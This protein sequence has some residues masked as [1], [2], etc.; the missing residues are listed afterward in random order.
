MTVY[1]NHC[2]RGSFWLL[3]NEADRNTN[4]EIT[5]RYGESNRVLEIDRGCRTSRLRVILVF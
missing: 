2:K 5:A 4:N 1:L 3:K